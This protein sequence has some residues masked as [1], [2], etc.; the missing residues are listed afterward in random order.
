VETWK[1]STTTKKNKPKPSGLGKRKQCKGQSTR[2]QN[3]RRSQE[4]RKA[5]TCGQVTH[6]HS[7]H[8][9]ESCSTTSAATVALSILVGAGWNTGLTRSGAVAMAT[10]RPSE[11]RT[12]VR[13]TRRNSQKSTAW[14]GHVGTKCP[15]NYQQRTSS[16]G[17]HAERVGHLERGH[18][19]METGPPNRG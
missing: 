12:F 7:Y 8:S 5:K 3:G 14:I 18:F 9:I 1:T 16:I 17:E 13:N 10:N 2:R 15:M 6:L 19:V 4:K 11:P